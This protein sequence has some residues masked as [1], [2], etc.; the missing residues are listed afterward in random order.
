MAQ[1]VMRLLD[2]DIGLMECVS[3]GSRRKAQI[4]NGK[5]AKGSW[6][7]RQ[8]CKLNNRRKQHGKK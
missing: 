1:K 5:F 3:C 6:Q 2:A 7:C 4:R 8:G